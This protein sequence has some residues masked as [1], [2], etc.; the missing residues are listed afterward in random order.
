MMLTKK[1]LKARI[2]ELEDT[3]RQLMEDNAK[4]WLRNSE[5][6]QAANNALREKRELQGGIDDVVELNK[7]VVEANGALHRRV[8]ALESANK[9]LR[10]ELALAKRV[11]GEAFVKGELDPPKGPNRPN[12][13]KLTKQ[14]VKDIRDAFRGGVKQKDLADNYGVNRATISRIVRGIY[15]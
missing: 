15:H 10:D 2:E 8:E 1:K 7:L 5:L 11:F 13:K 9:A 3:N 12:R 6:S 4:Q 14:E